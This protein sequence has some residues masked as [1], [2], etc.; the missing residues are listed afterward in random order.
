MHTLTCNL[1]G[2]V[3]IEA[4][5][6]VSSSCLIPVPCT[7]CGCYFVP[8]DAHRFIIENPTPK[9][10]AS[11]ATDESPATYYYSCKDCGKPGTNTF[12]GD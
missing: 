4:H 6:G 1:C 10:L 12:I 8:P 7:I 5:A 3:K 9:Y 2:T 11:P